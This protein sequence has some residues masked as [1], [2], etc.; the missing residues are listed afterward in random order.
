MSGA[1]LVVLCRP[2]VSQEWLAGRTKSIAELTLSFVGLNGEAWV[3]VPQHL[4]GS[5][6]E[7][8]YIGP[9]QQIIPYIKAL[10]SEGYIVDVLRGNF[11]LE[12]E[13][14]LAK[15]AEEDR[16]PLG[17]DV[18]FSRSFNDFYS[19]VLH[20]FGSS[21]FLAEEIADSLNPAGLLRDIQS[22]YKICEL[23]KNLK[24]TPQWLEP[25]YLGDPE[26]H[27]VIFRVTSRLE[28]H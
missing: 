4:K 7:G 24:K 8:T 16:E 3:D 25:E 12:G 15:S 17:Y 21:G 11:L 20:S 6:R 19:I 28:C 5:I 27:I 1:G 2:P 13:M 22:A 18:T 9:V 10:K 14:D 23:L 26:V